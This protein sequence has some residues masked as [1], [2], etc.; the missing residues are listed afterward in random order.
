MKVAPHTEEVRN[1]VRRALSELCE[2]ALAAS[3]I[4][5]TILVRDGKYRGRSFKAAGLMA[6]WFAELGF[7]QVYDAEGNMVRT[8]N[9]FEEQV[10]TKRAA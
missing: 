2:Q 4:S 5:E 1:V 6:M 7:V 8:I 3:A 9:L 10:A